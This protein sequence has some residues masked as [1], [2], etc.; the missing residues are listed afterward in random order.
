[1]IWPFWWKFLESGSGRQWWDFV[2]SLRAK[3]NFWFPLSTWL[4]LG[5]EKTL[6]A[7]ILHLKANKFYN[8]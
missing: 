6:E 2:R 4:E 8:N 5:G 1:M 3:K 7:Y